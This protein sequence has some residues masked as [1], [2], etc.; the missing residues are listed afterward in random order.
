ML[1]RYEVSKQFLRNICNGVMGIKIGK[2]LVEQ[3]SHSKTELI[4]LFE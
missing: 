1:M 3:I 4:L 2:D